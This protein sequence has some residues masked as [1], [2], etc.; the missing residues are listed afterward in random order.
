MWVSYWRIFIEV[1]GFV[2]EWYLLAREVVRFVRRVL[3]WGE[4][5][6]WGHGSK[7]WKGMDL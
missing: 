6:I 7:G 2:V 5:V 3:Y 1:D 4:R